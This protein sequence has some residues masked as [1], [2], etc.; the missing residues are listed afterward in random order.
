MPTTRQ[1]FIFATWPT[2]WPTAPAAPDTTTVSPAFAL[3]TSSR[4]K[5]AVMP[6]MPSV[7][8]YTGSGARR[9]STLVSCFAFATAYS[10]TPRMP[11]TWSPTAIPGSFDVDDAADRAGSHDLADAHR[12]HVGLALLH[13]PA[14]GRI[15]RDVEDLHQHLAIAGRCDG[16]V[17][18]LE[19]AALH[20]ANR[21]PDEPELVIDECVHD[22]FSRGSTDRDCI[23]CSGRGSAISAE[24]RRVS[25]A[26][27]P[28]RRPNP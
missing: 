26:I 1:P 8:R 12:R 6:G 7:P 25:S 16:Y 11:T 15:Q 18:V 19:V 22:G 9:G 3:P 27:A 20:H 5:Y 2:T 13:P 23:P 28:S 21:A 4:P 14:H 17:R 24:C 10:C